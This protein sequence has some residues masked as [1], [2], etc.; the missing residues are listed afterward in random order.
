ML[1]SSIGAGG[2]DEETCAFFFKGERVGERST[3]RGDGALGEDATGEVNV[4]GCEGV[5]SS[6]CAPSPPSS[7]MLPSSSKCMCWGTKRLI[8]RGA[9]QGGGRSFLEGSDDDRALARARGRP[10]FIK[11]HRCLTWSS[12]ILNFDGR[13]TIRTGTPE[14]GLRFLLQFRTIWR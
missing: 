5:G 11:E 6:S 7:R 9:Q 13:S 4:G 12:Q 1:S 3:P 2:D 10:S 14:F 8:E